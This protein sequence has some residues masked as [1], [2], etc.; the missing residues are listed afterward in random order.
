MA[1]LQIEGLEKR[2]GALVALAGAHVRAVGGEVHALLG[3]NGAG[4]STLIR[5]LSGVIRPD[6]GTVLLDGRRLELDGPSSARAAGIRTVFQELSLVPDLSVAENLLFERP[7]LGP[8][9]RVRRLRLYGEAHE[10]LA[11]FG[12]ERI[13]PARPAGTLG[14]A[15]RQ[16]LEVVKALRVPPAVLVLDEPTSALS[17]E[18]SDWV[19]RTARAVAEKGA[20]VLFIS[21]R[22]AEVR[23]VAETI[24]VLRSGETV[25]EGAARELDDDRL[26]AAMLGRRIERLYPS[27]NAEPDGVLLEVSGLR[28]GQRLGPL[29]FDV[30]RGEILGVAGLEGQGQRQLLMALGGAIPAHGTVLL[31]GRR[32]DAGTPARALASGVALVPEDRQREGLFLSH[33]TRRNISISSLSRLTFARV[34]L[35]YRR[36][37]RATAASASRMNIPAARL[38]QRVGALSGGN[39]QKVI[40]SKVLLTQPK[41]LLLHDCTRGVDVGTKAEIFQVM[42]DLA[43]RGVAI[44][45]YSSDLSELVN[46]C[47][48]VL[49]LHDGGVAGL[50]ERAELSE[51]RILRLAVGGAA[52][53]QLAVTT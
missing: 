1:T 10:L 30:R 6:A 13:D 28:V 17:Q 45:F 25:L 20:I 41:L 37:A 11:R 51:E 21:H 42:A 47:D 26:I 15:E 43:D 39:Q 44:L 31:E 46:M 36:E 53:P 48:R 8:L 33:S 5:I 24:T 4:K 19:L 49:V 9:R 29:D 40:F 32:F 7:P 12:L 27:R 38:D 16:L 34:F 35:D 3:E 2:Y 23:A 22:L 14:I 52:S 50:L 18:Q